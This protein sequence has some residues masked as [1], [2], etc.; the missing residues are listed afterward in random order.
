MHTLFTIAVALVL[1]GCA[2][3]LQHLGMSANDIVGG[4]VGHNI[5]ELK[6]AWTPIDRDYWDDSRRQTVYHVTFGVNA[7][8][9]SGCHTIP[10]PGAPGGGVISC[11][12]GYIP[13]KSHCFVGFYTEPNQSRILGYK[14]TGSRCDE[15]VRSWGPAPSQAA[16][17]SKAS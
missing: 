11:G 10:T 8:R 14:M 2:G 6:A 3:R 5:K 13:E 1:T 12:D 16:P 7:R 17:R 4:W 15:Y 9:T